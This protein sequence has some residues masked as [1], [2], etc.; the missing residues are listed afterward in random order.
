MNDNEIKTFILYWLNG[1]SEKVQGRTISEAF[2]LAGYGSG[3][4]KALDY[5]KEIKEE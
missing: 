2:T 5:Y 3:A 4:L 1:T